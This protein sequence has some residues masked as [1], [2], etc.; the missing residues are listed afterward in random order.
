VHNALTVL[1]PNGKTF[2]ICHDHE[3]NERNKFRTSL[4]VSEEKTRGLS[5]VVDEDGTDL[6]EFGL[7]KLEAYPE[8][9]SDILTAEMESL[10]ESFNNPGKAT[11]TVQIVGP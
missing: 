8:G 3:V 4:L 10:E 1:N 5:R 7:Y 9:T 2:K 6:S 11:S